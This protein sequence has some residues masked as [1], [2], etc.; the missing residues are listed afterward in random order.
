MGA[1]GCSNDDVTTKGAGDTTATTAKG[2]TAAAVATFCDAV[3]EADAAVGATQGPDGPPDPSA[4]A[5]AKKAMQAVGKVAP[6]EIRDAVDT[7]VTE[8]TAMFESDSGEPGPAFAEASDTTYRWM[9]ENCGYGAVDVTAKEYKYEGMP[10]DVSAG[11]S[12]V[13]LTNAGTEMHEMVFVRVNDDVTGSTDE[14]LAMPEDEVMKKIEIK[15][16]VFAPPGTTAHSTVDLSSGR[17]LIACF[18]PVGLTPEAAAAMDTGGAVPDGP[19]H[20]TQGMLH[21]VTID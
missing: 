2:R 14:L 20:F 9:G 15:G 4:V 21:E 17:Y 11:K 5:A 1:A 12:V 6:E 13:N 7:M 16:T 8:G 10:T 18:I 19:P 3:V